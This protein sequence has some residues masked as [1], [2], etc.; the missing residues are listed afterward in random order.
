MTTKLL[1][2]SLLAGVYIITTTAFLPDLGERQLVR[3]WSPFSSSSRLWQADATDD[4]RRR[5]N[6]KIDLDSPKVATLEAVERGDKKVY[7]RCWLSGAFPLCDGTH[8]KHNQACG[9][10]VGPL[11]V[12][13]PALSATADI[14]ELSKK[15][16]GRKKRVI[17][18]YYATALM[19]LVY[20]A[21]YFRVKGVQSFA[22]QVTSGYALAAGISYIL[23][24]AAR[25]DRLGSDTYKRLNGA[26]VLYGVCGMVGWAL[27]KFGATVPGYAPLLLAPFL[28]TVNG[29]KGFAYGVWGLEKE[30]AKMTLK[31]TGI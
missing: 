30:N 6:L 22:L 25:H 27:V 11:I 15:A 3:S 8:M 18:G 20:S 13:V 16:Q 26:L 5:I 9:D 17:L 2:F 21:S 10:N 1:L 29:I 24:G 19:Y 14:K 31:R 12:S 4:A 7:C 28:A 23:A